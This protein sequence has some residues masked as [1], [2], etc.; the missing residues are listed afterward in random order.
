MQWLTA[1]DIVL[2]HLHLTRNDCDEWYLGNKWFYKDMEMVIKQTPTL[3]VNG[4]QVQMV[5]LLDI[6]LLE[7]IYSKNTG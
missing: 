2:S 7:L 3:T 5:S 4:E 1:N 6:N